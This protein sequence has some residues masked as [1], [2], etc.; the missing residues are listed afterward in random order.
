MRLGKKQVL[1]VVKKVDFGVYL[2]ND[3]ERVLLPKKQVPLNVIFMGHPAE[4]PEARDQYDES[5][6]H[7]IV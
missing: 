6:V 1:T 4:E 3:E 7:F 5:R 2:G